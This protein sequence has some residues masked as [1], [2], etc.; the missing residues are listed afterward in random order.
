MK[1]G[2]RKPY[3][4]SDLDRLTPIERDVLRTYYDTDLSW[5]QVADA[6]CYSISRVYQIRRTA[7]ARIN[8]IDS[9]EKRL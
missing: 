4:D 9:G 2:S 5:E 7:L 8:S 1:R 3:R 6:L